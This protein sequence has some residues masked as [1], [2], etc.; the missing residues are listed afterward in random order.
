MTCLFPGIPALRAVFWDDPKAEKRQELGCACLTAPIAPGVGF[1]G[2]TLEAHLQAAS[3]LDKQRLGV[4][5]V[6]SYADGYRAGYRAECHRIAT[7]YLLYTGVASAAMVA[8]TAIAYVLAS[9]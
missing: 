7:K 3:K 9:N 6:E 1:L 4:M 8:V 5:P 2:Y